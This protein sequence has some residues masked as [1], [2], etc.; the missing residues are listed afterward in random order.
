MFAVGLMDCAAFI[1][2]ED[3]QR[4]GREEKQ[5]EQTQERESED[6]VSRPRRHSMDMSKK[7][8]PAGIPTASAPTAGGLEDAGKSA[9]RLPVSGRPLSRRKT[10]AQYIY[11]HSKL[12]CCT[13]LFLMC[14]HAIN[15]RALLIP[16]T[17]EK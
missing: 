10:S 8:R 9:T 5:N 15:L 1:R 4:H 16:P 14:A 7:G 17:I 13:T 2:S 3:A 6:D 11:S 12:L